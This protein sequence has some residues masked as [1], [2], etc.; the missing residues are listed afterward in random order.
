MGTQ[1]RFSVKRI[2][3]NSSMVE[4]TAQDSKVE[5]ATQSGD[6]RG[7]IERTQAFQGPAEQLT[8]SSSFA[9]PNA[10]LSAVMKRSY[11]GAFASEKLSHG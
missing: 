2:E 5:I 7:I 8:T 10:Q 3:L 1:F 6:F 9:L 4:R 11:E